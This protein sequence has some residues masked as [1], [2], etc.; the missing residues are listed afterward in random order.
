MPIVN[1]LLQQEMKFITKPF[2]Q[3][4]IEGLFDTGDTL[5]QE[6]AIS[7]IKG[8]NSQVDV[9]TKKAISG[10]YNSNTILDD[11]LIE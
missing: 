8:D 10:G 11:G 1:E 3:K 6:I 4:H 2:E 7:L 5:M 9:L